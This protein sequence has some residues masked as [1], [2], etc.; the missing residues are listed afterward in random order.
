MYVSEKQLWKNKGKEVYS[1]Q[2]YNLSSQDYSRTHLNDYDTFEK[3]M[4][5]FETHKKIFSKDISHK[6]CVLELYKT[7]LVGTHPD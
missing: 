6:G 4:I 1:L 2:F 5:G 3:A 7:F